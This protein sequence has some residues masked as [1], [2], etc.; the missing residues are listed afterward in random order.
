VYLRLLI[1]FFGSYMRV[2]YILYCHSNLLS[3]NSDNFYLEYLSIGNIY[4]ITNIYDD[5]FQVINDIGSK[6]VFRYDDNNRVYY[7][8]NYFHTIKEIR[9][10]KL[11][12]L[13]QVF[14]QCDSFDI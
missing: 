6:Y 13:E 3:H 1:K 9:K 12:R 7:Y 4:I 5:S 14:N 11:E 2:G 8:K 10:L